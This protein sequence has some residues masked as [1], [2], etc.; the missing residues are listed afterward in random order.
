MLKKLATVA[1]L[2]TSPAYAESALS[3]GGELDSQYNIDSEVMSITLTPEVSYA[4][5][6]NTFSLSSDLTVWNSGTE[7]WV[8]DHQDD[9]P[10]LDFEVERDL[11][12]NA[13]IYGKISYDLE[14]KERGDIAVGVS[15]S[16]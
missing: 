15:F 14:D 11:S 13:E 16:F 12:E 6:G 1:A 2:A 5:S 7:F 10:T 3:W 4:L 8:L 9:L